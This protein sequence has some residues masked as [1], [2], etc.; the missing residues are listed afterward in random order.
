MDSVHEAFM[1]VERFDHIVGKLW[2]NQSGY[3]SRDFLDDERVEKT[4]QAN[5][6]H[7]AN[8]RRSWYLWGSD[9]RRNRRVPHGYA[10]AVGEK[11]KGHPRFMYV[12][13]ISP[14]PPN[15]MMAK[16]ALGMIHH[17][18]DF[19]MPA[20]PVGIVANAVEYALDEES[21][22]RF[23]SAARR[24]FDENPFPRHF[25]SPPD[26]TPGP[27]SA[28]SR[29]RE[30]VLTGIFEK[31]PEAD[32]KARRWRPTSPANLIHDPEKK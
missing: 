31:A 15:R 23:S 16:K 17:M 2:I 30:V 7:V 21:G 8:R 26:A 29:I 12:A 18:D 20:L 22:R 14:S 9:I 19:D 25:F 27:F 32:V 13:R 11:Y 3:Y 28:L 24:M 6:N 10:V 1:A 5:G 4:W